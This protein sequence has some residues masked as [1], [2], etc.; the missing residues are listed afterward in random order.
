MVVEARADKTFSRHYLFKIN[1]VCCNCQTAATLWVA[2]QSFQYAVC[3]GSCWNDL[4]M[5][6]PHK[7]QQSTTQEV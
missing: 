2:G 3:C 7:D 4:I 6:V 1:S 5:N